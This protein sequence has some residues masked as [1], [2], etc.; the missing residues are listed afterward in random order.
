MPEDEVSTES[1]EVD[2]PEA[3]TTEVATEPGSEELFTIKVDGSEQQVTLSELQNGYQRQADY[4]RKTQDLAV[5]RERLQQAETIAAA[6][7]SDPEGTLRALSSAFGVSDNLGSAYVSDDS[8]TWTE[9]ED[10][11][12]LRLTR[13]E[14]QLDQQATVA[15]Q[16]ALDKEVTVLKDRYGDFNEQDLFSHAL[17][18]RIPNLDAAYAHMRFGEVA[19]TAAKLQA[20]KDV[21]E[22]KRDAGVVSGGKSTQTGAVAAKGSD[23][24]P[25]TIREAFALAKQSHT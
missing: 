16:Q 2:T 14:S 11:M 9:P 13:I 24:P 20:D 19:D 8:D 25:S 22:A 23:K 12:A 17:K 21:T 15:R 5:E 18:N 10:P 7:E 4:T 3:S 6:L 1:T